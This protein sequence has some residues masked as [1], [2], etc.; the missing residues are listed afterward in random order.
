[1]LGASG[2]MKKI[3]TTLALGTLGYSAATDYELGLYK[4]LPFKAHLAIDA[5]NG[6][7]VLLLALLARSESRAVRAALAAL[8]LFELSAAALTNPSAPPGPAKVPSRM[9]D[10]AFS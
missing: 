1:M 5:V 9:S 3:L 10:R 4:A 6:A 7:S 8:G 2:S